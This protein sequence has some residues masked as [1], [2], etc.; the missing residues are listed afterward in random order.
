MFGRLTLVTAALVLLGG[1]SFGG[2]GDDKAVTRTD[3]GQSV[4]LPVDCAPGEILWRGSAGWDCADPE[5]IVTPI[6]QRVASADT[7]SGPT[8]ATGATGPS[9]TG[10]AGGVAG[11]L[12][13]TG[14]TGATGAVG[15]A[16]AT[17][18][19]GPAGAAGAGGGSAGDSRRVTHS[20]TNRD[21]GGTAA[22]RTVSLVLEDGDFGVRV[23]YTDLFHVATNGVGGAPPSCRWN[24]MFNGKACT[25]P[26]PL[27]VTI[28]GPGNV[29]VTT[30]VMGECTANED[31]P[32]TAGA[33]ALTVMTGDIA[34]N[35]V[36]NV[37]SASADAAGYLQIEPR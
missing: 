26:G 30:T 28:A 25:S 7:S 3:G 17:G 18:P 16:G 23:V 33:V 22:G 1:C 13:A 37:G 32:L 34:A 27:S 24:V 10:A 29:D 6:A 8:G 12:G 31:G 5:Q 15:P 11:A 36:C 19:A 14:P 35:A 9:G 21:G 20:F 2:G 4:T